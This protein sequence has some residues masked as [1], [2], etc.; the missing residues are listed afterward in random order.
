[1]DSDRQPL[2]ADPPIAADPSEPG[3]DTRQ[4]IF[5]A[6]S[7][8]FV[9]LCGLIAYVAFAF[10]P[11][12]AGPGITPQTVMA[13]PTLT[14]PA[15]PTATPTP[16]AIPA[17]AAPAVPAVRAVPVGPAAAPPQRLVYPSADMDVVIHPLEPSG[18]DQATQ[19]IVPPATM[20]GYWLTPYG[21]PGA[22]S[23][24]TT[25][26][27]GHDWLDRDAPFNHLSAKAAVGDKLTLSTSTGELAYS[28]DSVTTYSKAG[29]KDSP[30]WQ[31]VPNRLVLI[32][33][34]T[35]DPWGTNVVVVASPD[36]NIPL[37]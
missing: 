32:S 1:M 22:G 33:C 8:L 34:Y 4:R 15:T 23:T 36:P 16:T 6:R 27:A 37:G 7:I 2:S 14:A 28:V 13:Q 20:D 21:V 30:I 17:P 3:D 26:V 24:N 35:D 31:V 25:Y 29:L 10:L 12:A 19:S 9:I 11:Q 18:E 5:S